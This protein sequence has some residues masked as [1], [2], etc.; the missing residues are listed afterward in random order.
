MH[1]IKKVAPLIILLAILSFGS[2]G[3]WVDMP[4]F[5]KCSSSDIRKFKKTKTN[6]IGLMIL[7]RTCSAVGKKY[8]GDVRCSGGKF[9]IKCD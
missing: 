8:A 4:S 3:T 9:Q 1:K 6:A 7:N 2:C 5:K